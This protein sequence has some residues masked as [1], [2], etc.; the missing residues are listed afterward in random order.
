MKQKLWVVLGAVILV[1]I[2]WSAS[3]FAASDS[4]PGSVDD[5]IVT[6]GYVDS[7]VSKL[8]Q[9]ELAKQGSTGGGGSSK[10]ETVTVPWGTKLVV[11]DGG[12][13]IVRTGK[14]IAYSSDA[15]GLSD[16]TDG[17]DVKPG[18]P[19]K[20]DHLIL[21]PRGARGIEAD[22]KQTKGLIVLVRGGYKLQ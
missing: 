6:K 3:S 13:M 15:N 19:V 18:K 16:L 5:P 11:E 12:E 22:P 17:L 9:Q 10:L 8:V 20:N 4:T 2:I 14:A 21:N 7:V 1:A